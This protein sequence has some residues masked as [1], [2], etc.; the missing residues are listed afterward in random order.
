MPV[1]RFGI[2]ILPDQRWRQAARRWQRAEEF[3]FDHAWTYDHLG[4]RTLV[5]G[6]WFDAVPTL[7]AAAMVTSRIPLG[8]LVASPNF[9][10]PVSFARQ[11]TALDD[12]SNGRIVLGLGAGAG[13][14]SFDTRVLGE[15][16]LTRRRARRP[17]RGVRR[18]AGPELLRTDHVT[19]SG[20]YYT[21]V[22][23]RNLPGCLQAAADSVRHGGERQTVDR[24]GGAARRWLGD[25]GQP[26][27]R[28]RR[29]V[30]V[31][32]RRRSA[33][34]RTRSPRLAASRPQSRSTSRST[35]LALT[36]CRALA[37]LT[38]AAGRAAD[39]GFT[40]VIIHWPRPDGPYAGDERVLETVAADLLAT[41]DLARQ[42]TNSDSVSAT[43]AAFSWPSISMRIRMCASEPRWVCL[44]SVSVASALIEEPVSTGDGK[45]TRSSP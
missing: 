32:R 42:P 37:Y 17:V 28:P 18:A 30:A 22:D 24:A 1:V 6:P 12:I 16:E 13:G 15:P 39:L 33:G 31:S 4:W 19:W 36:R 29:V 21:A 25:N 5:D 3:G 7:T 2:I 10:H 8:T 43:Q 35:R 38:D 40:D 34:S 41:L 14:T 23:A 9:R 27:R 20:R 45:R 44:T 11:L 26:V